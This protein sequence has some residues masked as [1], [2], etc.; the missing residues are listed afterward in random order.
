MLEVAL[1]ALM[2]LSTVT[3]IQKR[4][5]RAALPLLMALV[6][7]SSPLDVAAAGAPLRS[8]ACDILHNLFLNKQNVTD[9]YR[10]RWSIPSSPTP[11]TLHA[12]GSVSDG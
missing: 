11:C 1:K 4:I 3:S 2:N 10:V 5:C 6:G 8:L 12:T 9:L 7:L